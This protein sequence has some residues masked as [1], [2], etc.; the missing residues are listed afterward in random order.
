[1]PTVKNS[2]VLLLVLIVGQLLLVAGQR[3][4]VDDRVKFI[5]KTI[6]PDTVKIQVDCLTGVGACDELGNYL[7]E[8]ARSA[9]LSGQCGAQCSCEQ[10]SARLVV[11]RVQREYPAQWQR[12][13]S[14]FSKK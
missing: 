8:H 6:N 5:L 3:C 4:K 13:V 11:N 10:I 2:A 7:H 9:V 1:M 12:V 14:H